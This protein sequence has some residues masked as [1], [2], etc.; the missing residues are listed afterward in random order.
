LNKHL[1]LDQVSIGYRNTSGYRNRSLSTPVLS[2]LSLSL[3]KGE[4][5]SL[6]GQSGCGKSTLLRAIAGFEP[7]LA[8]TITLNA[9]LISAPAHYEPPEKRNIGYMFQDFA[10]FPHLSA[11][12]NI[13][14]GLQ[15]LSRAARLAQVQRM[16]ALVGLTEHATRFPHELSG[17]QQQRVAL[18][19]ALATQPDLLLLDEP[20]SSLDSETTDRLI[21]EV[22]QIIVLAGCTT[23]MVTHANKQAHAMSDRM[24]VLENGKITLQNLQPTD[25]F[26]V[27]AACV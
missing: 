21:P 16:L 17:G 10:L 6:L 8:G 18:A 24:G 12:K 4:I 1:I 11:E 23:L 13:A 2:K 9:R 15:K 26:P 25:P 3:A 20:F 19:R 14:F 27:H 5:F 22:R 7:L